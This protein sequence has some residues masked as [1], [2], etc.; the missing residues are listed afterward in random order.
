M[1]QP[2]RTEKLSKR[3][4]RVTALDALDLEVAEGSVYALVGP[5]GAGKTTTLKILMNIIR[6]SSG[7]AEILGVESAGLS[8][9][10]LA[11]IGYVSENQEMPGWMTVGYL[12]NYLEPFYPDWDASL[13]NKLVKQFD[14]PRNREL[15]H[16]SRGMRMKAALASSLA[17]RPKLI[18]L[19]EPFSGLDALVRD[20]LVEGLLELAAGATVLISSHDLAEIETFASHIGYLDG[21][22]LRFS[23]DMA[24]L[25]ERFREVRVTFA[26]DAAVPRN[27]PDEWLLPHANAAMLLF[28]ET[29]FDRERS[30]AEIRDLFPN[31]RDVSFNAMSLR[32][33]FV[34]LAKA[35]RLPA[36]RLFP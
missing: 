34:V 19:D 31:A 7:R 10:Q 23:D 22:R 32:E 18:V 16:L 30:A 12:L 14:L 11:T 17:Y 26:G 13:A 33:I 15:K 28:V 21:G 35:S 3:F 1:S 9:V 4:R 24:S 6:A 8:P 2:I 5:N 27:W 36:R 20:E 29:R 25:V